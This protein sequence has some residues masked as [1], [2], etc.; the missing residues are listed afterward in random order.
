[1]EFTIRKL[2]DTETGILEEMLYNAVFVPPGADKP[3]YEIVHYPELSVYYRDFNRP[4]DLCLVAEKENRIAGAVWTRLFSEADRGYGFV[5]EQTPELS[6]AVYEQFRNQGIGTLLLEAMI[7]FL[8]EEGYCKVSLS[9]DKI[10]YAYR[11]YRRWGFEDFSE[12]DGS[13]TM[14][15]KLK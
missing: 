8:A 15:R 10:N 13:V 2:K 11:L 5:D 1:M 14:V 12:T 9:V 4:G 7:N 6:M 3:P